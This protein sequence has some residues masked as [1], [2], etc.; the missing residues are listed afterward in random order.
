MP[1][2]KSTVVSRTG[3]CKRSS[4]VVSLEGNRIPY[5]YLQAA[6]ASEPTSATKCHESGS[7]LTTSASTTS[8]GTSSPLSVA[9]SCESTTKDSPR[10]DSST[11]TK[12]K[13]SSRVSPS[14]SLEES[15]TKLA[16]LCGRSSSG[17]LRVVI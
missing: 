2:G 6:T 17:N 11:I 16:Q 12:S 1:H 13:S 10:S 3:A 15:S 5:M 14:S 4:K 8:Q 7:A 9:S